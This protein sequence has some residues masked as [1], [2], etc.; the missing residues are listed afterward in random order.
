MSIFTLAIS[1]L[2]A[3]NF[4]WFMDLTF[5]VPMQ[6]CSLQHWTLLLSPVTPIT[7]CCFCFGSV[8]S[9]FLELLLHWSPV[10]FW[11]PTDLGSSPFSV[12]SFCLF[13]QEW[14]L[15]FTGAAVSRYSTSKVR[16]SSCTSLE[17]PWGDTP[18]KRK[19]SKMVG[20]SAAV[21]RYPTPK[22][23]RDTPAR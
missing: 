5:Q 7:G 8:S 18:C 9:F 12:L 19:P 10:T 14:W 15:H 20:T 6:Y 13:I 22:G 11:A 4:P 23:K 21:R 3:S 17:R 16:S 2:T 1:C